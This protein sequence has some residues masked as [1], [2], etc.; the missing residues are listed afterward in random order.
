MPWYDNNS[1]GRKG[2]WKQCV[3]R[4]TRQME[5]KT[6]RSAELAC[7]ITRRSRAKRFSSLTS[8]FLFSRSF[9]GL[10]FFLSHDGCYVIPQNGGKRRENGGT[11]RVQIAAIRLIMS[12]TLQ[13]R[14]QISRAWTKSRSDRWKINFLGRRIAP[15]SKIREDIDNSKEES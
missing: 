6:K 10:W 11:Q 3:T 1:S 4:V 7:R 14:C 13:A 15:G 9:S 8:P 2:E 5:T 12:I